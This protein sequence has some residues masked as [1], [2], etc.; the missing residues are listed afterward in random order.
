MCLFSL[1]KRE[2]SVEEPLRSVLDI[3]GLVAFDIEAR[4]A[5]KQPLDQKRLY[6]RDTLSTLPRLPPENALRTQRSD[7][8]A[9]VIAIFVETGTIASD[10]PKHLVRLFFG[11]G[12]NTVSG[13]TVSN[14]E[15]SEFFGLPEFRGANSVSSFQPIICVQM[16]THRVSGRTHRVCRRTQ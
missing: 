15:L 6:S 13:S 4:S 1:P 7:G 2:R 9:S 14:T 10:Y 12:P 16:R 5:K 3:F 8:L 11:N